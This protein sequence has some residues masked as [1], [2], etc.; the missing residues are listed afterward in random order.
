MI[1]QNYTVHPLHGISPG[2]NAPD[3]VTAFI[4]I[5]PTDTVKYVIAK[6]RGIINVDRP[7]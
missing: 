2:V 6:A 1:K 7:Q 5:V 3:T 4:E